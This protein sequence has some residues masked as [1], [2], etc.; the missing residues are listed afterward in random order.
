MAAAREEAQKEV[1]RRAAAEAE[2][3]RMK[4]VVEGLEEQCRGLQGQAGQA[5]RKA[6]GLASCGGRWGRRAAA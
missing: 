5:K 3:G 4:A 1:E 6:E 2:A